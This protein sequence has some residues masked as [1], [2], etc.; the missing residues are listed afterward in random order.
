MEVT[1]LTW[2]E[3]NLCRTRGSASTSQQGR[4]CRRCR[5]QHG[6]RNTRCQR[7]RFASFPA[8]LPDRQSLDFTAGVGSLAHASKALL[9]EFCYLQPQRSLSDEGQRHQPLCVNVRYSG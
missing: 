6:A 3:D 5:I 4:S 7:C 1:Y 8:R 9:A 2:T